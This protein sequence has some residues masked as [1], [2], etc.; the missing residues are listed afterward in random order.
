MHA[1]PVPPAPK[2]F[3]FWRTIRFRWALFNTL[4][5][6]LVALG[7]LYA[8]R[9]VARW[10]RISEVDSVLL[11]DV[12]EVLMAFRTG[13]TVDWPSLKAELSH[14][15]LGHEERNWTAIFFD[16]AGIPT[17]TTP[18]ASLKLPSPSSTPEGEMHTTR[19]IRHVWR[20]TPHSSGEVSSVGIGVKI[21]YID[22]MLRR[23][24]RWGFSAIGVLALLASL[25][26][27]LSAARA[28]QTVGEITELAARME[29]DGLHQRL[30]VHDKG[31]ELDRLSQTINGFLDRIAKD[32]QQKRDFLANSAHE[33]RTPLAAIRSSVEVALAADRSSDAYRDLL[34][35]IL[36][37]N[38]GLTELVNQLLLLSEN[39]AQRKHTG[40]EPVEFRE[41]VQ[42][43][44]EM[45][46]G[47]TEEREQTLLFNGLDSAPVHGYRDHLRQL[48]NNLVVNAIRYTPQRGEVK[49]RLA[50]DGIG[51]PMTFSVA[52][53]GPGIHPE[54]LPRI[55]DR[56]Y[57]S[58]RTRLAVRGSG[59]GLSL[60]KSI[61]EAHGGA[62]RCESTYGS[63]TTMIVTL[64]TILATEAARQEAPETKPGLAVPV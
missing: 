23:F 61:A 13:Q 4:L 33:L 6:L 47:V 18:G 53:N 60:C 49:V 20:S 27:Y 10:A 38:D 30:P 35:D 26:G 25:L 41:L 50:C 37:E 1:H 57:R 12:D 32:A 16:S 55:F 22:G 11:N 64:P 44:I 19:G 52:D 28:A 43:S 14:E 5:V 17:W 51:S 45:F 46:R 59:L 2:Q 24:D 36:E 39:D 54:D 58:N 3:A 42:R 40:W 62:I 21:N 9:E 7:A 15:A 31:D 48:I 56:F 29:A 63:G 34:A 8:L